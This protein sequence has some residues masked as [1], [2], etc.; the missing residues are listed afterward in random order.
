MDSVSGQKVAPKGRVTTPQQ[1][2]QKV[3]SQVDVAVCFTEHSILQDKC[4]LLAELFMD[5]R[6]KE[7]YKEIYAGVFGVI[8]VRLE[9]VLSQ[10]S[11][12]TSATGQRTA[13]CGTES[14]HQQHVFSN[15][16]L[17]VSQIK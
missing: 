5:E 6:G 15:Y 10:L 8:Q 14:I 12:S 11:S 13:M 7:K 16:R 2:V 9:N 1:K 4:D 3:V 17:S